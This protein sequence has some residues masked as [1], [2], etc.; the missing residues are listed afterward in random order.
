MI[1]YINSSIEQTL[2][3][4]ARDIC[5]RVEQTGFSLT[6]NISNII[7]FEA[8]TFKG[9]SKRAEF[10]IAAGLAEV[11]I[12]E[13]FAKLYGM[14]P[15]AYEETVVQESAQHGS[16]GDEDGVDIYMMTKVMEAL[17]EIDF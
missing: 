3:E 16:A 4:R 13:E 8:L 2:Q 9:A 12:R 11:L 1:R 5:L 14:S 15:E 6:G 7:R 17:L 10:Q